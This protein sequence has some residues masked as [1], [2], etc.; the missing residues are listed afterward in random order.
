MRAV[1]FDTWFRNHSLKIALNIIKQT[2]WVKLG[3][4]AGTNPPGYFNSIPFW[5]LFS[6]FK[7]QWLCMDSRVFQRPQ[8]I[9]VSEMLH[10]TWP[11]SSL[12]THCLGPI[13][14]QNLTQPSN[15]LSHSLYQLRSSQVLLTHAL[16][17][18]LTL[19]YITKDFPSRLW[20]RLQQYCGNKYEI[21]PFQCGSCLK[22]AQLL[23][24]L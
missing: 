20:M 7:W 10:K 17:L 11:V 6:T 1:W 21:H 16:Q 13:A 14:L 5:P 8:V 15:P 19:F 4:M 2:N 9:L 3:H 12:S 23:W 22:V 24:P 18:R